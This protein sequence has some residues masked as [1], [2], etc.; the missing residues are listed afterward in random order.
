MLVAALAAAAPAAAD[1]GGRTLPSEVRSTEERQLV[2]ELGVQPPDVDAKTLQASSVARRIQQV[3]DQGHD[4]G[5]GSLRLVRDTGAVELRWKGKLP[6]AVDEAVR[7][8]RR[9][10]PVA[11][12]ESRFTLAELTAEI[13]RLFKAPASQL[14]G[15]LV[16][17]APL[18]DA[19]GL[20]LS[21]AGV[22][23]V[24][25]VTSNLRAN[26]IPV[27]VT[28]GSAI[29][30]AGRWDDVT[31]FWGG[32]VI[33]TGTGSL[34]TAGFAARTSTNAQVMITARHCGANTNWYTPLYQL[35][36]GRANSGSVA[37]D[38][39]T[40][41][42]QT[43]QGAVFTG[44]FNSNYGVPIVGWASAVLNDVAC[45]S[46]GLS[47]NDCNTRI[48]ETNI[49]FNLNGNLTGPAFVTEHLAGIASVGQG[50]SGGP[51]IGYDTGGFRA[52]GIISAVATGQQFEGTC[53]GYDYTGRR[54]SRVA[55]HINIGS[56][57]SHF[58]LTIATS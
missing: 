30:P 27:Q 20:K 13:R 12:V 28:A 15:E 33:W 43:Y 10:V 49:Y 26:R 6:A 25:A 29:Q 58:N 47:G 35:Y 19:S 2:D 55:L 23:S 5:F 56:I 51:T 50:D 4:Q 48:T 53:Q 24:S 32:S 22:T 37:L 52:L 11:V 57:L 16:T 54:C 36:V 34:C 3:I 1:P 14:G 38:A 46:G 31:P 40:I 18:P 17:A 41:S 39:M 45:T 8:G 7:A 9:D 21:V 42:E 44:P